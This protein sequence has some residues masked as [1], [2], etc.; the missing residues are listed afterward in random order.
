MEVDG[1]VEDRRDERGIAADARRDQVGRGLR[2]AYFV[3]RD[4]R[5]EVGEHR[6]VNPLSHTPEEVRGE[7]LGQH[8][9]HQTL[10]QRAPRPDLSRL[11]AHR[12]DLG[13]G[14][15]RL[16]AHG[17]EIAAQ[18]VE[19]LEPFVQ[20]QRD[21]DAGVHVVPRVVE[22]PGEMDGMVALDQ[23]GIAQLREQL[24]AGM[25][26][27]GVHLGPA[28]VALH[29]PGAAVGRGGQPSVPATRANGGQLNADSGVRHVSTSRVSS[30][31]SAGQCRARTPCSARY[32]SS[33]RSM[34]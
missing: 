31:G 22:H 10:H 28:H 25:R 1:G 29:R 23:R 32:A 2:M 6:V 12:D 30:A 3:R 33:Q 20:L 21:G 24:R 17:V 27:R 7:M 16:I 26:A 15:R 8:E 9:L 19:V 13:V 34:P 11:R 14:D 18:R 4:E 5:Q